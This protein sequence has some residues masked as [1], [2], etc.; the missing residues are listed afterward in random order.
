MSPAYPITSRP[1]RAT[2]Y[3]RVDRNA[4]SLTNSPCVHGVGYT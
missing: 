3:A 4:S 2:T 1:T